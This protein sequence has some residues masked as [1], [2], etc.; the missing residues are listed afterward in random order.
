M[1][2]LI[3]DAQIVD[4]VLTVKDLP[5]KN[6]EVKVVITPKVKLEEMSFLQVQEILSGVK[7]DLAEDIIK[8]RGET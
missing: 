3:I 5:L 1:N 2:P 6:A 7:R 8:E 4:G